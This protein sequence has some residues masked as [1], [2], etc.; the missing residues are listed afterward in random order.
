M[1]NPT[2]H[3]VL[4]CEMEKVHLINMAMKYGLADRRVITQSQK[5]DRLVNALQRRKLA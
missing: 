2:F 1:S 3:E 4:R 5:V